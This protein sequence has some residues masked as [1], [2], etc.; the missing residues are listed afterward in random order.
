MK[1]KDADLK[2]KVG[3]MKN[4]FGVWLGNLHKYTEGNL[5]GEWVYFPQEEEHLQEVINRISG[6]NKDELMI[7]DTDMGE[8]CEYLGEMIGE[9]SRV[10]ELNTIAKLLGNEEHPAVEAYLQREVNLSLTELANLIMQE[11]EIAYYPY[12]F[13]GSDDQKVMESL[14]AEE[15]MGY[16]MIESD[17]ELKYFLK[18]RTIGTSNAM[19]YFDAEAI[20]RDMSLSDYV[21][22][23]ED[24]YYNNKADGLNLSAYTMDEIKEELAEREQEVQQEK[25]EKILQ[26]KKGKTKEQQRT[27]HFSPS[28]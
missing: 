4:T 14:S 15:K 21:T 6:P 27:P 8:S 5:E 25:A 22:L 18:N 11:N 16:T 23:T 12:E 10:D 26:E 3:E 20:G 24:G 17:E 13:D 19:S 28:L 9:W 2:N 7:F 1:V